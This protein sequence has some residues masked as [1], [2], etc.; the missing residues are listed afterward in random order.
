MP[1]ALLIVLATGS[2][3]MTA[4]A[5]S[6]GP[7]GGDPERQLAAA[8]TAGDLARV[9]ALLAA[10]AD[11]NKMVVIEGHDQ[12]PWALALQQLR[13]QHPERVAIAIAML[14]A[15]AS[16]EAAWGTS[17][18]RPDES[19]W[20]SLF[21]HPGRQAGTTRDSPLR[22]VMQHPDA[23]VVRALAAKGLSAEQA[24]AQLVAAVEAGEDE[25]AR[26]LVEAGADVNRA[27]AP[28]TPLVAAIE[29]RDV[30][31]MEFLEQ[32]GARE[33]P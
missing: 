5:G 3:L 21:T 9:Q 26:L 19:L 16:P 7:R 22:I 14:N 18:P 31:M 20:R 30:A 27:T 10:G 28:I 29:R 6:R 12:S 13:P 25:I 32:H 17:S 33:K 11:P 4:C 8:A 23:A 1:R 2:L 24:T 15:G